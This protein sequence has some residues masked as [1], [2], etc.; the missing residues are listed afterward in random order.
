MSVFNS[1]GSKDTD[2]LIM[3][4]VSIVDLFHLFQVSKKMHCLLNNDAF[5]KIKI[6]Y[7]FGDSF[8]LQKKLNTTNL[9]W[10]VYFISLLLPLQ[11]KFPFYEAA[12]ALHHERNDIVALIQT[13]RLKMMSQPIISFIL[14]SDTRVQQYYM[15]GDGSELYEGYNIEIVSGKW[16]I[17]RI[18]KSGYLE[19]TRITSALEK[20]IVRATG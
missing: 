18:Y 5:W 14:E 9:S 10:K 7:E 13:K 3:L 12:I 17:E 20:Q 1:V 6:R 2:F 4:Q 11:S 19:S 8:L 15:R 16:K